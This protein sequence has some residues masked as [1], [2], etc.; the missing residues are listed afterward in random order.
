[1]T[2]A[3]GDTG[4]SS[5]VGSVWATAVTG[6]RCDTATPQ[7]D[8][9]H[10]TAGVAVLPEASHPA[11]SAAPPKQ[12]AHA[13]MLDAFVRPGRYNSLAFGAT[14]YT[15]HPRLPIDGSV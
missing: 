2:H 14:P 11:R 7:H 9:R 8:Y 3:R 6:S 4:S 1:M 10:H 5:V 12:S 13:T 15:R